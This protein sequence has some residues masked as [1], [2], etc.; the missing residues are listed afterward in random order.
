MK[1]CPRCGYQ[2]SPDAFFCE[3][4]PLSAFR[5]KGDK[6]SKITKE[7]KRKIPIIV[8]EYLLISSI[9]YIVSFFLFSFFSVYMTVLNAITTIFLSLIICKKK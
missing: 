4:M 3:K 8:F 1:V 7:E 6:I 2:N 9:I 5:N